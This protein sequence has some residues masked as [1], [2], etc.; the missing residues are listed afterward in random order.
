MFV[1]SNV[2]LEL[3]V[4]GAIVVVVRLTLPSIIPNIPGL[5][6]FSEILKKFLFYIN[7]VIQTNHVTHIPGLLA[8]DDQVK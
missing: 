5:Q 6:T 7:V 1:V 8:T 4:G 3:G 2:T